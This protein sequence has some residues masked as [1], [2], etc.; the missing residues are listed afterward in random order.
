MPVW[1]GEP[2]PHC[3]GRS[4]IFRCAGGGNTFDER[5]ALNKGVS[6]D[7]PI[8][9]LNPLSGE[10]K[11]C[12]LELVELVGRNSPSG[13][14]APFVQHHLSR[15]KQAPRRPS[16]EGG[17]EVSPRA[18]RPATDRRSLGWPLGDLYEMVRKGR[19][20]RSGRLWA[21]TEGVIRRK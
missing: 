13:V 14:V 20:N 15:A 2:L 3:G 4:P 10:T 17:S 11:P 18:R 12:H 1:R 7:R 5:A 21:P 8:T 9:L 19:A 6:Q 16:V